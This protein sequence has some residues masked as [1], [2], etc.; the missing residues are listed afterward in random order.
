MYV[1]RSESDLTSVKYN[2]VSSRVGS[3][4]DLGEEGDGLHV[5]H[6]PCMGLI[7]DM[8]RE[9]GRLLMQSESVT[10]TERLGCHAVVPVSHIDVLGEVATLE[11]LVTVI[12]RSK[13]RHPKPGKAVGL[14]ETEGSG[15]ESVVFKGEPGGQGDDVLTVTFGTRPSNPYESTFS[16]Y[17]AACW[18]LPAASRASPSS[19]A[20]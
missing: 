6:H 3:G 12:Q 11:I 5:P 1:P 13:R 18:W 4:N 19:L 2:A 8:V 20:V 17:R 10:N 7:E 16:W 14:A 9:H 15:A